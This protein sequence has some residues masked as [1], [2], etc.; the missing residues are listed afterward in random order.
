MTSAAATDVRPAIPVTPTATTPSPATSSPAHGRVRRP[1]GIDLAASLAVGA[2]SIA[3][4]AG[5]ARV[6]SGWEF[7]GD[8]VAIVLVGHGVGFVSRRLRLPSWVSVPATLVALVW[9]VAVLFY[10]DTFTWAL[11]SGATWDLFQSE[12]SSVR[13]QFRVSVAPVIYGGGWDVLAAVGIAVAVLLGD[14]F[15]FRALAR[16]ETLVP[17]G[18]LFIFVGALGDDRLRVALTVGLV[19]VGVATTAVLRIYHSPDRRRTSTLSQLRRSAPAAL[20]F[21]IVVALGAGYL[22]PRLPG[23]RSEALYETSGGGGGSTEVVSPLV[24]IRSRLTNRSDVEMFRVRADL[25]SY[26]RTSTLPEF[27]GTTWGLAE[28]DLESTDKA[29]ELPLGTGVENRQ[30][31]TIGGLRGSFV[32][33]AP[34]PIQAS[35]RADLRWVPATSTLVIVDGDL[36]QGDLI[37]IMSLEPELQPETLETATSAEPGDDIYTALPDDLPDVVAEQARQATAGARNTF[38]AARLLQGWFQREFEYSLE[39]QPGHGNRAIESFLRERVGYCEQFAGTYAAMMRTLGYPA[40]VAVGFTSGELQDDGEFSVRG[41]NAH[42]WPEVWFDDIGWVAFE[43]TPGRGAPNAEQYTGIPPRQDVPAPGTAEDETVAGPTTT[44]AANLDPGTGLDLPEE[45]A[46]PTGTIIATPTEADDGNF[47]DA[48]QLLVVLII[49]GLLLLPAVV[50]RIRARRRR[51]DPVARL[52]QVWADSVDAV[53]RAGV[54]VDVSDTPLEV[55][56][57]AAERLPI[58]ARPISD[59]ADVITVATF[60]PDGTDGL[61]DVN[62]YGSSV[63]RSCEGWGRQIDHAVA[64]STTP[65]QRVL[66]YFT[67]WR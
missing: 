11:P 28:Q 4:A 21:V 29:F 47:I 67:V 26:W 39:V 64:D 35:G 44:V 1:F 53:Q 50:R 42:A 60:G 10:R 59:L 22:G 55:A 66:R 25:E 37:D 23:A 20:A 17:G 46:D 61:G 54:P 52:A 49:G 30:R 16:V 7:M 58:V 15:A 43:P 62:S 36:D 3:V 45:F 2:F 8:L 14:V 24:D 27:D 56:A 34:E 13:D 38:E 32:P 51:A 6:F 40:R 9:V 57:V 65:W 63:L 41:R 31:I 33:A 18:V 12:M 19:A 5:F 48:R